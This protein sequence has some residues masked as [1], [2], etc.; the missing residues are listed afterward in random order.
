M[1]IKL[2]ILIFSLFF[3]A[4][5]NIE[6]KISIDKNSYS[7]IPTEINVK[8][9]AGEKIPIKIKSNINE[10]LNLRLDFYL[11]VEIEGKEYPLQRYS[12]NKITPTGGFEI[13][14]GSRSTNT[15]SMELG[16]SI[17]Q[18]KHIIEVDN[19]KMPFIIKIKGNQEKTIKMKLI[20]KDLY[21]IKNGK[22][23]DFEKGIIYGSID[24]YTNKNEIYINTVPI[25][26]QF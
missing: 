4:C 23:I 18:E 5:S 11:N 14:L 24:V 26:I 9:Y 16:F 22:E 10:N 25:R 19:T 8:N 12:K 3:I 15:S 13:S 17:T 6:D 1:K 21:Y 2:A 7:F 20:T